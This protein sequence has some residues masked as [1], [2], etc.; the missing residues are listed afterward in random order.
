VAYL[1]SALN[2]GGPTRQ[3]ITLAQMLPRD[4][5][6]IEFVLLTEAGALAPEAE[7][8]GLKIRTLNWA[9][10]RGRLHSVR[11]MWEIVKLGPTLRGGK[12]D[13][14]DAQAPYSYGIAALVKPIGGFRGLIAGR[15][16]L[17][18]FWGRPTRWERLMLAAARRRSDVI[19]AISGAVRDDV[20][21]QEGIAPERVRVIRGGVAIPPVMTPE[22]RAA[23][24]AGWGFG[25]AHLVVGSVANL[26]GRK[27]H[28]MLVR[29]A[30]SIRQTIPELRLVIVGEG[31]NRPALE[32]LIA[33]LGLADVV[34]LHGREL[35]ARRLYRAFDIFAHGS[36][37]EGGPNVTLEA[38]AAALPIVATRAGGTQEAVSDGETGLLVDVG[39]AAAF[40]AALLRLARDP[41]L[42]ARFGVAGQRRMTAEFGIDRLAA[43]YAAL[44]E[45]LAERKGVRR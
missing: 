36:E 21:A 6:E 34:R 33:E 1:G 26:T 30:A 3:M 42:R 12:Y 45:E 43:E 9:R 7:R 23:I 2:L 40:G 29:L 25:P 5:F 31:T 22:E 39:D 13:L 19:V 15:Q 27:G 8:A 38:A 10:H 18:E 11:R 44:Y 17:T 32:A 28:E 4:R 35:D 16:F 14:V 24:R 20:I 37:T 41:E